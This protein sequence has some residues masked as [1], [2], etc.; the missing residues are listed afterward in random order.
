MIVRG[1]IEQAPAGRWSDGLRMG[2]PLPSAVVTRILPSCFTG[3]LLSEVRKPSTDSAIFRH[4][5]SRLSTGKSSPKII[6]K[7]SAVRAK[8]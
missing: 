4:I 5:R 2:M 8:A 6:C 7:V 1:W 3:G